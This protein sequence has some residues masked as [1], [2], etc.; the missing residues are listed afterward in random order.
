MK[1]ITF[2]LIGLFC[3]A[4]AMH[5]AEPRTRVL[6]T[7]TD[8]GN[9]RLELREH[10]ISKDSACVLLEEARNLYCDPFDVSPNELNK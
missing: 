3:L 2:T 7:I 6:F 5:E 4:F 8:V 9:G 10:G 1:R